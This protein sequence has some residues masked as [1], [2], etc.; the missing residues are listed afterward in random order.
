MPTLG[1]DR[2]AATGVASSFRSDREYPTV[3]RRG[4]L[5]GG[6]ALKRG[7]CGPGGRGDDVM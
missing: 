4:I 5:S 2:E 3:G 6:F 1:V 7:A